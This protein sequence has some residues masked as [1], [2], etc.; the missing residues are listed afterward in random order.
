MFNRK[1]VRE[2]TLK[3]LMGEAIDAEDWNL[4][5]ELRSIESETD[6]KLF[7]ERMNGLVIGYGAAITCVI[8]GGIVTKV[9]ISKI[10]CNV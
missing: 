9:I 7:E 5:K 4:V 3:R 8:I 1:E 6:Q 10:K 2:S